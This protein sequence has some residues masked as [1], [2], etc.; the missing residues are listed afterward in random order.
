MSNIDR[1]PPHSPEAEQSVLGSVLIDPSFSMPICIEK[2]RHG[3]ETFYDMRHKEIY[4][5]FI[6]LFDDGVPIDVIN[7]AERLKLWDKL[8]QVGGYGYFTSLPDVVSSPQNIESHISILVEKFAL[9]R[10]VHVCTDVVGKIY[11]NTTAARTLLDEAAKEVLKASETQEIAES[12]T[13]RQLV[14]QAINNIESYHVHGGDPSGIL[15]G[16]H[17]FDKMTC[18]LHQGEM[19]VIA[20]RP[21]TGKTSLAMNIAEHVAV[22]NRL[23]VGVFSLEM[24]AASLVE[25][26]ICSRARVNLRNVR[27]GFLAERDFPKITGAAGKIQSAP[28][29]I[30]DTSGL[31]ILQLRSKARRW[32]QQ[33]GIKLIVIDYLQLANASGV[34]QRFDN[35]QQEV[36]EI[37]SGIKNLAKELQL[38]IIALSQMNR[39]FEREKN[40]KP[41]M[42]DL[43]ESGSLEQ[44]ADLVGLLYRSQR[45]E[46]EDPGGVQEEAVP[47][48][49]LIAKQRQGP[50]GDV[51]LIF[52]KQYTRFESASK[53]VEH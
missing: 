36:S 26:M 50:T 20:G 33:Y 19:I 27:D 14:M 7:V 11:D 40:R 6:E 53:V 45:E 25:R 44:D 2:L 15:T 18:G 12:K 38:P 52:L 43:R 23:P 8:E 31:S 47:V 28:L 48:N 13:I 46:D 17:D 42:S 49:L 4:E 22:Q 37:S 35:R 29:Y 3:A 10:M 5:T 21:S 30:D 34:R 41:R 51:P 39:E 24:T 32:A 1:L 16:F 9:R